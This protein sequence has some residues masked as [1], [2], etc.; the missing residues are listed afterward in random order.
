MEVAQKQ[1]LKKKDMTFLNEAQG[2]MKIHNAV[3]G[4]S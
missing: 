3:R 2:V 4:P 1:R